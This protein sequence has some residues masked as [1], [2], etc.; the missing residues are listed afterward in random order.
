M[1]THRHTENRRSSNG[2]MGINEYDWWLYD[3][4]AYTGGVKDTFFKSYSTRDDANTGYYSKAPI[5]WYDESSK[6]NTE[7]QV[8]GSLPTIR[9]IV[10][11]NSRKPIEY[12]I[13]RSTKKRNT[14]K[15]TKHEN[16]TQGY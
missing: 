15:S 14:S 10:G 4:T 3:T 16:G 7:Y 2:D 11:H 5:T 13:A 12:D 6:S 1:T 8:Q 9:R